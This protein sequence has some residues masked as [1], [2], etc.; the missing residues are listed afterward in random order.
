MASVI[1]WKFKAVDDDFYDEGWSFWMAV[2]AIC[3][4]GVALILMVVA[5]IAHRK[6]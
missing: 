3:G 5:A 1:I 4:S 2:G 6:K